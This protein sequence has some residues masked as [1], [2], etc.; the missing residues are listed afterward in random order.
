MR[1][2]ARVFGQPEE[3]QLG[4]YLQI[5]QRTCHCQQRSRVR[6]AG[7]DRL[8]ICENTALP[9]SFV[10]EERTVGKVPQATC[11]T[12][13]GGGS[14]TRAGGLAT[15]VGGG[16]TGRIEISRSVGEA[17]V[18]EQMNTTSL[19]ACDPRVTSYLMNPNDD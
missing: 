15:L 2:A 13:K 6:L 14:T 12:Q 4:H 11:S 1:V 10:S 9:S 18:R 7:S 5:V 16:G 19:N 3:N 8:R 17:A